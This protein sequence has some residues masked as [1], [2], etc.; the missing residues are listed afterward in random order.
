MEKTPRAHVC[1]DIDKIYK[2]Y[3]YHIQTVPANALDLTQ[4]SQLMGKTLTGKTHMSRLHMEI[5][6]GR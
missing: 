5:I 2:G 4:V 1:V 6:L 3:F